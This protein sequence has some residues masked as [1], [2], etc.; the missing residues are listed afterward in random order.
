MTRLMA[1]LI[2]ALALVVPL[3]LL[4]TLAAWPTSAATVSVTS[5][6]R[7]DTAVVDP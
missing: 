7:S 3:T 1:L 6:S 5:R 2:A 4:V